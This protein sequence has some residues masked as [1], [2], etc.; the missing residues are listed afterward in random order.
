M[1]DRSPAVAA[2]EAAEV[3]LA[4]E[5]EAKPATGLGGG[6]GGRRPSRVRFD[7]PEPQ[8][9]EAGG[10]GGLHIALPPASTAAGLVGGS[11]SS[12][13]GSQAVGGGQAAGRLPGV[14]F[15]PLS[16]AEVLQRLDQQKL[17]HAS[18]A[19]ARHVFAELR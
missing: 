3:S 18:Q 17:W 2:D 10:P 5:T 1:G 6:L 9:A 14:Q 19:L 8:L 12:P 11:P 16:E 13:S 7:L 4:A 15:V